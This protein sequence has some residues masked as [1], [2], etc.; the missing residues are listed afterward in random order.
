VLDERRPRVEAGFAR[1]GELR[2]R[3]LKRACDAGVRADSRQA[4]EG[5]RIAISG[6]A[7]QILG[8][9]VLLFE[10]GGNARMLTGHGRPPSQ[11]ARVRNM[12]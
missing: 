3:E 1:D 7:K 9:F 10:V 12:G 6:I 5:R 11:T 4:S 8:E 2:V